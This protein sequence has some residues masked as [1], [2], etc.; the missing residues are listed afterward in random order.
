[1]ENYLHHAISLYTLDMLPRSTKAQ[2]MDVLSSMASLAGYKAVIKAA[3]MYGSVLPMF[4]TAAGTLTPAKVLVLGAGV[5]GLQAIATA[6][7]LGA[8]VEAFDVR[9][10]AGEEVLSL[11]AKFIQ[12]EGAREN[13]GA[14]GYAI[15]QDVDYL[16]RQKE[17]I[18]KHISAAAI[19]ISTANIPGRRA[20]VLIEEEM[21]NSMSN[22]SVIVDLASEQGGNCSLTRDG[23]VIHHNGVKIIGSSSL[24]GEI[25]FA[26][27]QLLSNN[28]YAFIRHLMDCADRDQPDPIL[29]ACRIVF[30]GEV[31]H[32]VFTTTLANA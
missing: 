5:A 21:V 28:Y 3:E 8:V 29:D 18:H 26:S 13:S 4:T 6:R 2:H 30:N 15:E 16:N 23:E 22:G 27:S 11:G 25:A 1:V 9:A 19:V 14:G 31:I 12:V 20:P 10:S 7:R 17:L 32:P 24:S